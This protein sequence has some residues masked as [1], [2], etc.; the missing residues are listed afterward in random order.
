MQSTRFAARLCPP[1]ARTVNCMGKSEAMK[2]EHGHFHWNE[3]LTSDR[4]AAKAF[5]AETLGWS[6]EAFP[7][8]EGDTYAVCMMDGKPVGG[9]MQM[10]EGCGISGLPDCWFPYITVDDIDARLE[11]VAA[12]G[13]SIERPAFEIPGVGRIAIVRDS[14]GSAVGWITPASEG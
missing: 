13:G 14:A 12:A 6:Y 4:E 11:T 2:S 8:A 5:Y 9:M 1:G 3:L 7:T 10:K